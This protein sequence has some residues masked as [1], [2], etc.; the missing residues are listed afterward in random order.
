M[1]AKMIM[2]ENDTNTRA[3]VLPVPGKLGL[4]P[5]PKALAVG[6]AQLCIGIYCGYQMSC[7][8]SRRAGREECHWI[9]PGRRVLPVH[10]C[11][12]VHEFAGAQS[13]ALLVPM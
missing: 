11:N 9:Y 3:F 5:L 4:P 8:A 7:C 1:A 13:E 2:H 6:F 10:L 12:R